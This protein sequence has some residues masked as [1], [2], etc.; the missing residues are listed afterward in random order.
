M[1]KI[2]ILL[3]V[4]LIILSCQQNQGTQESRLS[5]ELSFPEERSSDPL[6]GRMLLLISN[7]ESAEPRFQISDGPQTQLVFGVDV[8]GLDPGETAVID[9]EV[10]SI[11]F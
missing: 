3:G 4:L 8:D 9:R 11:S 10:F 6:D 1:K 7:D 5:F 2:F